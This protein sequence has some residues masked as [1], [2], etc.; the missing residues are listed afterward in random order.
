V[1][2][3]VLTQVAAVAP[4]SSTAAAAACWQPHSNHTNSHAAVL[5]DQQQL[6]DHL[7]QLKQQH[8][9]QLATLSAAKQ[10]QLQVQAGVQKLQQL[11]GQ[12]KRAPA[13]DKVKQHNNTA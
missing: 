2:G 8:E 7:Q 3:A 11:Y 5:Q 6:Q 10:A 12:L 4:W 1:F 13:A 9:Q